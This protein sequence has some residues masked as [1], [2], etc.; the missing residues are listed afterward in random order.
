MFMKSLKQFGKRV[1]IGHVHDDLVP[2]CSTTIRSC[3]PDHDAPDTHDAV[4]RV[5]SDTMTDNDEKHLVGTRHH[6][7]EPI[8]SRHIHRT[9]AS[10]IQC[11]KG[12]AELDR[13]ML[14]QIQHTDFRR[15]T[16]DYGAITT[17]AHTT[18]IGHSVAGRSAEL[19]R[20][21]VQSVGFI[22][23]LIT[24]DLADLLE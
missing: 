1:V 14:E 16:L 15:I 24:S 13:R 3:H 10:R 22:T 21:A 18:I 11:D 17:N 4:F 6:D 7:D 5:L 23:N 20:M 9:C 8:G 12:R 2:Y 19:V